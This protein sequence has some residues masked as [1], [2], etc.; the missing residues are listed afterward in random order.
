MDVAC[1]PVIDE[2]RFDFYPPPVQQQ[3]LHQQHARSS[4]Q[5]R[6]HP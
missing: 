2:A 4:A 3:V 1:S 5:N 6:L